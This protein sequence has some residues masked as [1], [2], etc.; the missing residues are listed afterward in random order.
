MR[1]GSSSARAK[2]RSATSDSRASSADPVF[3]LSIFNV[4]IC[5][6]KIVIDKLTCLL[7]IFFISKSL[8][9]GQSDSD[10]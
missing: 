7:S 1:K 6:Y 4:R 5:Q 10:C 2:R 8:Y 3:H 9:N